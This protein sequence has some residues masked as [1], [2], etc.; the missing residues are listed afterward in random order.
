[1]ADPLTTAI[2]REDA[3]AL[4]ALHVRAFPGFFLSELGERFLREFYGGFV[5][6]PTAVAVVARDSSGRVL[7]A[8]VGSTEPAG[9][10]RRLLR[11][12]LLPLGVASAIAAVRRPS[13]VVRLLRG[14]A[15]RGG[16]GEDVTPPGALLSS[17]CTAPD[18]RGSG[19]GRVLLRDWES[20]ARGAGAVQAHLST[21][22][23]D[24]TSV[25]DFYDRAGWARIREYSTREGRRMNLYTKDLQQ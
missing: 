24:N 4:A 7:G 6:D 19:T 22:A 14:V 12:R 21:D 17:I 20:A 25:H 1:M 23:V 9:F 10:Y 13:A 11:R 3:P 15:Y 5:D 2:R 16:V 18:T 8:A